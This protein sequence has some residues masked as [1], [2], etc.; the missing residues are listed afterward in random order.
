MFQVIDACGFIHDAYGTF[1]DEDGW[2][3]FIP[4]DDWGVF[5][6]TDRMPGFYTLYKKNDA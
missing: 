4:C 5:Y 1:I 3:Q 6:K 2:I